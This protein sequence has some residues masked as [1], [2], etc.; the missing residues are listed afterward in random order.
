MI[1]FSGKKTKN[2]ESTIFSSGRFGS[3]Y[4]SECSVVFFFEN[5]PSFRCWQQ[6]GF[7]GGQRINDESRNF[8]PKPKSLAALNEW[9]KCWGFPFVDLAVVCLVWV[10]RPPQ[11]LNKPKQRHITEWIDEATVGLSIRVELWCLTWA[12]G[13]RRIM[14][15]LQ[16][17]AL[18]IL[19]K[20]IGRFP[21]PHSPNKAKLSRSIF[22]LIY[23]ILRNWSPR[24]VYPLK[25]VH[26]S[27]EKHI[28][29]TLAMLTCRRPVFWLRVET[30]FM[31]QDGT[32]VASGRGN[33]SLD[34]QVNDAALDA[35]KLR[36]DIW[37][38]FESQ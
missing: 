19:D 35:M 20:Q 36:L 18:T 22:R 29:G 16:P 21:L 14:Q 11:K 2:D 25:K 27:I 34:R 17:L 3:R 8:R 6:L 26:F 33:W 9:A 1:F 32:M 13:S 28:S 10:E 31:T 12:D 15:L 30:T 4:K 7:A 24:D 23:S 37:F 5:Y 38:L